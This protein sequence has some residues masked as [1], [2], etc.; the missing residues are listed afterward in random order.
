[1]TRGSPP[2]VH[3]LHASARLVPTELVHVPDGAVEGRVDLDKALVFPS[4]PPTA[5][6]RCGPL[7]VIILTEADGGDVP[8]VEPVR[9]STALR[10]IAPSMLR[11]QQVDPAGELRRL[12]D[13]LDAVP[14]RRLRLSVDRAAN[15]PVIARLIEDPGD[16]SAP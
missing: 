5:R 12:R 8:R 13:L 3:H 10:E 16:L 4:L 6:D 2:I 11:Q 9:A 15:P 7:R 14:V 1:V